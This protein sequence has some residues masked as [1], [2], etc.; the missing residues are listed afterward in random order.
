MSHLN[1]YH[2]LL[3]MLFCLMVA[4]TLRIPEL[5]DIPPGVHFDEAANGVLAAEIGLEGERPLFISSYTGKEV[6]FFYLA[7]GMM[8]LLGQSVFA[9]RLT[10][11][12]TGIVT[13][14]AAY[15]LGMEIFRDRRIALMAAALLA[16]SFWHILLSRLGFRAVT[17]PLWQA[18]AVAALLRGLYRNR[19]PWLLF[20]GVSAGLTAYTYLAARLFP[21]LLLAGLLP[22]LLNRQAWRL[23]WRQALLFGGAALAAASPLLFY[24]YTHPDAFWVRISQVAP[25]GAGLSLGESFLRSLEMFFLV[26][27]PYVRF[28]IPRRPL[29]DFFWGGLLLVGWIVLIW[30]LYQH[31]RQL[32][33]WQRSGLVILI[34]APIIMLLPTA[35]AVNEIVPSNLRAVGLIPFVFYLPAVGLMIFVDDLRKRFP[36]FELTWTIFGIAV[37]A[38]IAGGLYVQRVYFDTWAEMTE[39][40]F[41]TD[42]DM[43]A[44]AD[45]LNNTNTT[46]K[47][48]FLASLHYRHPTLAFLSEKYNE[49]KWLPHSEAVVFPAREAGLYIYPYKSPLPAWA[50]RYFEQAELLPAQTAVNDIPAYEAF[51]LEQPPELTMSQTANANFGDV[52]TLL[53]F[54]LLE[55]G[56]SGGTIP[57]LL[58]WQV[59]QAPG[60]EYTPFVH[61]EDEW[62]Y[63]WGQAE[64]FA[65]P[66]SQWERGDLIV[67]RVEVPVPPG[68]PPGAYRLRTG[69]F[70]PETGERLPR[71]DE[72]GRYAGDSYVMEP[73]GVEAAPPPRPLPQPPFP[74]SMQIQPGLRL[75]G[76]ERGP[77]QRETGES[78][79]LALWWSAAEPLP[80]TVSRF[81]L[82]RPDKTGRILG[83]TQPVHDTFPF[84]AWE[85]PTFLIDRQ[86]LPIPD[87]MPPGDY[88][89]LL[90]MMNGIG[91]TLATAD[92]GP[93]TIEAAERLFTPPD[94]QYPMDAAFGEEIKLIGYSLEAAAAPDTYNLTLVWQALTQPNDDYTVFVHLLQPDGSCAPC[95]WQQDVMPQQG[96]YPTSRWRPGE[97]VVD[98]YQ[99]VLPE[100][101]PPGEYPLEVGLYIAETGQRL[102][103]V[104]P[105]LLDGDV[106][107]LRP[108]LVP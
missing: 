106:V 93:L 96:Q 18:L 62:G 67:Q 54:D 108:L 34:L 4:A 82:Y 72:D 41:E 36:K 14:A 10:A 45:F 40:F 84:T 76:Y 105:N 29:F 66:G 97:V 52:I 31:W 42:G 91:D 26:G 88:R 79:D 35:L 3:F 94:S 65:Y 21:A 25:G 74:L 85:A 16:I 75:L 15:W 89:I 60:Q 81:E 9:L 107:G 24:F 83:S 77:L 53:G 47:T 20:A 8:R 78:L 43:T 90:R 22:V 30:R 63:R 70:L 28:N 5:V 32:P 59:Q 104:V 69:V 56:Q 71:L 17:Q 98:E 99:I 1:R 23:R 7:G 46:G 73:V 102:R 12:F 58:Y 95:V 87:D 103:V 27:D 101:T 57:L 19:W 86:S 33:D 51:I 64:T 100:E 48:I 80:E 39:T 38:L 37:L 68:T 55:T 49:I 50:R 44:V 92:L 61:L 2:A 11:A 6:L 13:V